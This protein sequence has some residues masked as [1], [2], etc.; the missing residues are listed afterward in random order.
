[1]QLR[2]WGTR[3]SIAKAGPDTVRYG[4]NT[5]CVEVRSARGT[6]VVLD[7]GTG[8]HGLSGALM[9][10]ARGPLRGSMLITHTHW[11]HIQGFPFFTPLRIAGAEWNVYGPHGAGRSLRD[12]M[13]GQMQ[14]S[15]FPVSLEDLGGA[16]RFHDLVEGTFEIDDIRITAQYL[17]HT[18]L[19]IGYRL[20][21]DGVSVVYATDHEPHSRRLALGEPIQRYGEDERHARF[22]AGADLVI[23]D[24]QYTAAEYPSKLGWGHSTVEY[25][26]DAA[27]SADV[28]RLMLFHHDPLRDDAA[29]DA[30]VRLARERL[31]AS[32]NA[33][34][35]EAAA[36]GQLVTLERPQ[37]RPASA[38]GADNSA[39][40]AVRPA[41]VGRRVVLGARSAVAEVFEQAARAEEVPLTRAAAPGDVVACLEAQ[42]PSLVILEKGFVEE[43]EDDALDLCRRIHSRAKELGVDTQLVLVTEQENPADHRLEAKAGV[44]DW[45]SEPL[46]L[47]YV[48]TRLRSWILRTAC[49]WTR[50][51]LPEGEQERVRALHG[52]A[53]LDTVPEERFDRYTRI[54][55]ALFDVP[56]AGVSLVDSDR[57]WFKSRVGLASETPRDVAFCAH[58]ILDENV[59]QV[60]DTLEDARFADNP[61]VSGSP[62]IRFYAG[63][64][65]SLADGSR[66]GT[67]CIIDQRP[68]YLDDE[69]L[70]LLDDL[71]ALVEA[72]LTVAA[73]K[74]AASKS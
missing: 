43:V 36:E 34:V 56:M 16:V 64:P 73:G 5:C 2:F 47:T 17:N 19:T 30:L 38:A 10:A 31:V 26:V 22:L 13:A 20:D 33:L 50:P 63:R 28:R 23:H 1:M 62:H 74:R 46:D 15:Y 25:V 6:L 55:A 40:A 67:L 59:L 57:Q 21:V 37:R 14:Y 8:A 49:R 12:T 9:E 44:S 48:R 68:R 53:L 24:A 52:L 72:E 41:L 3:G 11:D 39:L 69:Q 35:V 71:A 7:C 29:V 60:P 54:A 45:L 61:L 18:A 58:A 65:L 4:G 66:I 70:A 51:P 27:R 32:T 42:R